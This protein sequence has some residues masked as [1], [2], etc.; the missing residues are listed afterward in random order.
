MDI[1]HPGSLYFI[2][3]KWREGEERRAEEEKVKESW[4]ELGSIEIILILEMSRS[5]RIEIS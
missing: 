3:L 5:K 1:F 2:F 4:D